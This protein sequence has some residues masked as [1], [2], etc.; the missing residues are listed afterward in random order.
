MLVCNGSKKILRGSKHKLL[1]SLFCLL[2][3]LAPFFIPLLH[4]PVCLPPFLSSSR[5]FPPFFVASADFFFSFLP[6]LVSIFPHLQ[7]LVPVKFACFLFP[8]LS[9]FLPCFISLVPFFLPSLGLTSFCRETGNFSFLIYL[10][11]YKKIL[12]PVIF[13]Y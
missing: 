5:A 10:S 2:P 7:F 9:P 13:S 11:F 8:H 12:I 6:F 4:L 3:S 1:L